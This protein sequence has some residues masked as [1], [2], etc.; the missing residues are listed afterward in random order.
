[1]IIL[2]SLLGFC[3]IMIWGK[4]LLDDF[5][6]SSLVSVS[7]Q[8]QLEQEEPEAAGS[9][10]VSLSLVSPLLSLRASLY[11]LF[12]AYLASSQVLAASEQ[13]GCLHND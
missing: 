9:T 3:G 10:Q 1:M 6:V 12:I 13:L 8:L 11:G 7:W 5:R 4:A 2:L